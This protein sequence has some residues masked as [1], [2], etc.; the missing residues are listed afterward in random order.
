MT[1]TI[2]APDAHTPTRTSRTWVAGAV[3]G[4]LFPV[5]SFA[6][7]FTRAGFDLRR[8]ALSSLVLGDLGWLQTA[9]FV[10]TGVLAV[11]FAIGVRRSVAGPAGAATAGLVGTYGLGMVGGGLFVPDPALGWPVGAPAGLP[12]HLSVGATLHT[13]FAIA[14][15]L[16][17]IA[18]GFIAAGRFRRARG[19]AGYSAGSAVTTLVLTCLPWSADTASLRFAAGAVL[20]SGWLVAL[21]AR[22]HRMAPGA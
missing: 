17:L 3:A 2:S 13:C 4:A 22:L 7:A 9:N 1:T 8:H 18:A 14:A 5:V 19:W 12:E 20:I 10:A 21:S 6:Q 16:S 15:F 11:V